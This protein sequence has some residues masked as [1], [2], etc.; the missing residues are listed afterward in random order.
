MDGFDGAPNRKVLQEKLIGLGEN[1]GRKSYYPELQKKMDDLERF[2]ALLDHSIDFIFLAKAQ[3]G[4]ITDINEAARRVLAYDPLKLING[5]SLYDFIDHSLLEPMVAELLMAEPADHCRLLDTVLQLRQGMDVPVEINL[6]LAHFAGEQYLVAVARDITERKKAEMDLR[7]AND[8]LE[9][10]VEMRTQE[11]TAMNEELVAMNEE[12]QAMNSELIHTLEELE[13]TKDQLV[14]SEKMAA[15]GGL[16]AGVAHEIN[17]P[18]GIGVTL[19]SHLLQVSRELVKQYEEKTL[20]RQSFYE[21]AAECDEAAGMLLENLN[22][23]ARL[24]RD[25]KQVSVDQTSEARRTF[26]LKEYLGIILFSLHSQLKK[27]RI[28]VTVECDEELQLDS[29]PGAFSQMVTNLLMN[30]LHHAYGADEAGQITIHAEKAEK[31][32][33]FVYSDDGSGMKSDVVEKIFDPFFTTKRG[34]GGSGLGLSIVY[35]LVT[36]RFRGTVNC[37]SE[38]GQGAV[39]TIRL[40]LHSE[41][42]EAVSSGQDGQ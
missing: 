15:L 3:S 36:Q 39:F 12:L 11:L 4:Q 18:V 24:I 25:F 5:L 7:Q 13:R 14:R 2:K 28:T 17:T 27:T 19:A 20:N 10:K 1:S 33:L 16:V 35:N 22:R 21:F 6:R 29:F 26:N 37:S 23:A 34:S 32:L 8:Q 9:I 31:D 40:P 38:P 30:S 42:P 41:V